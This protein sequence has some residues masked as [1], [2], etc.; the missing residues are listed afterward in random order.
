MHGQVKLFS[1]KKLLQ[2]CASIC[3]NT[4]K[5]NNRYFELSVLVPCPCDQ[6]FLC[7]ERERERER[8][9]ESF[10]D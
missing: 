10:Q 4:E 6:L 7:E 3:I 8:E 5:K 2:K 1:N 9:R